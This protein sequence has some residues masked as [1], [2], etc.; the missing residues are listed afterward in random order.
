M[1][2]YLTEATLKHEDSSF[3]PT[4]KIPALSI[5][6][7]LI[8][9]LINFADGFDIVAMS[10]AA[11]LIATE[12][13]IGASVLG[14]VFSAAVIGMAL[15]AT[16]LSTLGDRWG[17][18]KVI[19]LSVAL[20][21]VA[22]VATAY[23]GTL[24]P[25]IAAR[26]VTGLGVGGVLGNTTSVASEY[27]PPHFRS[28]VVI[29]SATGFTLGTVI[30]GPIASHIIGIW[31]WR[32]V[33]LVGGFIGMFTFIL[34]WAFL[35]ESLDFLMRSK[36]ATSGHLSKINRLHARLGRPQL[37]EIPDISEE[38]AAGK[39]GIAS[40]FRPANR[41]KTLLLWGLFFFAYWTTYFLINWIPQLLVLSGFPLDESIRTLSAL[42]LGGL[43]AAWILG[44]LSAR[45]DLNKA[46]AVLFAAA[47][48]TMLTYAIMKPGDRQILLVFMFLIGFTVNG[49]MTSLYGLAAK[50]YTLDIR[51]TGVGWGIGVGR[52]G[53]VIS[54]IFAGI[55]IDL[56]WG[57]Y[58]LLLVLAVPSTLVAATLAW[59]ARA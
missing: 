53:A 17:R 28:F 56:G 29:F 49:G 30:V 58:V 21:S 22:M 1:G 38:P 23:S 45:F 59:K 7:A 48:V 35:P 2:K 44:L 40:L 12:M 26:F 47:V 4:R 19:L 10:V 46:I 34:T 6:V 33:F 8:C 50:L 3:G 36:G 13:N 43:V 37:N 11:P 32:E 57:L 15:G 20:I 18:K 16:V 55:L 31:G 51:A 5:V 39:P 27:A 9:F 24:L 52:L 54:P 41:Q 25:L 42:T 14:M